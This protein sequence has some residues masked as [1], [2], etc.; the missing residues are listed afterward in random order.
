[1]A[2]CVASSTQPCAHID[3]WRVGS[4]KVMVVPG[5]RNVIGARVAIAGDTLGNISVA[6]FNGANGKTLI[7][8]VRT[9]PA[10]TAWGSV[11]TTVAPRHTAS[12]N[13]LQAEG[14]SARLDLLAVVE[15]STAGT[16]FEL[17][18][19][20]V[21]PGLTLTAKPASLSHKR[22]KKVTLTVSDAGQPIRGAFVSCLG[23]H[24]TTNSAGRVKLKVRKGQPLGKHRCTAAHVDYAVGTVTIKIT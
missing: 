18:Q 11:R 7:H 19:T 15:P 6:W 23:K 16:P 12:V 2:Y 14:S 3:L 4:P 8:S 10:V 13:D 20:Q 21:L 5:S 24:G 9:N 22:S 17:F 1:M